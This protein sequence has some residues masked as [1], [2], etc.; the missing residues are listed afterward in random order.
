[1]YFVAAQEIELERPTRRR[2]QPL[3]RGERERDRG[4]PLRTLRGT[5][6]A[7]ILKE[8]QAQNE[9]IFQPDF[10]IRLL[11]DVQE[12][13]IANE[14]KKF[15]SLSISGYHIGEAG[16]SPIQELAF[17]LANG[18][19]YVENFRARGMAVNRLCSQPLLLLQG[20]P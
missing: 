5:M 15:Y 3:S 11:G 19:T 18:F 1:M 8:V 9:S 7:D 20:F 12:W 14:M 13:F 10:A 16:A 2:G 17:T 6:Q 4:R